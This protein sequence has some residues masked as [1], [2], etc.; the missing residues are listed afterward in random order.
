MEEF[1]LIN[2]SNLARYGVCV[3]IISLLAS[4]GNG[5]S[6]VQF[7]PQG[8]KANPVQ[9]RLDARPI[10]SLSAGLAAP[11]DIAVTA[12]SHYSHSWMAPDATQK[13]LLYISNGGNNTVS[14]YSYPK[15]KLEGVLTGFDNPQGE[16]V[17][18]TGNIWITNL[19]ASQLLEYAHGGQ[20]PI[21]ILNDPNEWPDDCAFDPTTG[22]LAVANNIVASGGGP[23]SVFIYKK[24]KGTPKKYSDPFYSYAMGFLDYDDKGNLYVDDSGGI[25]LGELPKGGGAIGIITIGL[26]GLAGGVKWDGKYLAVGDE[27]SGS[28][29]PTVIYQLQVTG[30]TARIVSSTVL[31]R[32]C[33]VVQFTIQGGKVVGPDHCRSDA[34]FWKYPSGGRPTYLIPGL[35]APIGTAL[36]PSQ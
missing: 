18:K 19:Y 34:G 22:D 15:G 11:A 7:D 9:P 13:D 23:G 17:D 31:K 12:R 1:D 33:I 20:S 26:N 10:L 27:G 29:G 3:A 4:C 5:P 16:C 6:Q 14:V 25:E 35:A 30:S 2:S 32:S 36:S 8:I 24:A 28:P 21:K